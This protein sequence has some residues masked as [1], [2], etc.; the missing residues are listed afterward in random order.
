MIKNII[1]DIGN[2][3]T[4]FGWEA[5]F[6]S[7]GF[8]EDVLKRLAKATVQSESWH[9]PVLESDIERTPIV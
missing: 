6:D 3:L 5:F 8:S 2:V 4:D 9:R 1:F 7:F